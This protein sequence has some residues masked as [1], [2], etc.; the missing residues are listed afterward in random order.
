MK[1]LFGRNI[2]ILRGSKASVL[3]KSTFSAGLLSLL[4]TRSSPGVFCLILFQFLSVYFHLKF[5]NGFLIINLL[6]EKLL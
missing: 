4:S 5:V 1:S 2:K 3:L 6:F